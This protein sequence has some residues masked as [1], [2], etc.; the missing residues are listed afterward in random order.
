MT[1]SPLEHEQSAPDAELSAKLRADG[2]AREEAAR[3]EREE[4]EAK[5]R[6]EQEE[7]H[8]QY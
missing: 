3:R 4:Q 8:R 1:R 5:E 2:E 7:Q 6:A